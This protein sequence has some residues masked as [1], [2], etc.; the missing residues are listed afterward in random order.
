M[1]T[2]HAG[3]RTWEPSDFVS[4]G[5]CPVCR[6]DGYQFP[7]ACPGC[8]EEWV[9]AADR[10]WAMS[11]CDML[12]GLSRGRPAK[13]QPPASTWRPMETA[14]KDGS[15]VLLWVSMTGSPICSCACAWATWA[16]WST[17]EMAKIGRW[18]PDRNAWL[19]NDK[20]LLVSRG[21]MPIP[22]PPPL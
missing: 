9:Q 1:M 19:E 8:K 17:C 11:Q 5:R 7:D 6:S 20:T 3:R 18:S 22:P 13:V 2:D 10:C 12:G 16:T 15:R 21:W 14:P 4:A